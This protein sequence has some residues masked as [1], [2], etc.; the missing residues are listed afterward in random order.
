MILTEC[1]NGN[2]MFQCINATCSNKV[3]EG[4][5]EGERTVIEKELKV[6]KDNL[7]RLLEFNL[8]SQ[9]AVTEIKA[10]RQEIKIIERGLDK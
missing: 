8:K 1:N 2:K 7:K 9:E 6:K 5:S 10:L 3:I 4:L